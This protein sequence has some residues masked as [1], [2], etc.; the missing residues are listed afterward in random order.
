MQALWAGGLAGTSVDDLLQATGLSR[1]SL[2]NSFGNREGLLAEA[3]QRYADQQIAAVRGLFA[4]ASLEQALSALLLDAATSNHEGRGCLLVNAV[5]EL[6]EQD[7]PT[8][9]VVRAAFARL[10]GAMEQAIRQASPRGTDAAQLCAA[11]M[12]SIAGMRTLQR[13]GFPLLQRQQAALRLAQ[14]LAGS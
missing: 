5:A 2:Y 10:A 12:A 7:G 1:S 13:A 11:L 4:H 8:A 6:H 14:A 3:V 9:D